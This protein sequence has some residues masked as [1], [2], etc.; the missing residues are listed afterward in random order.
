[1]NNNDK[2]SGNNFEVKFL[3]SIVGIVI[4]ISFMNNIF[5]GSQSHIKYD[6]KNPKF[7]HILSSYENSF[8]EDDLKNFANQNDMRINVTYMGD[9][10]IVDELNTN[11]EKY[12]A[13]WISNSMWLYMLNN[14]YLY[15]EQKSISISPVIFGIKKSKAESL[16]LVGKEVTN[17]DIV[18]LIQDKKISYVMSSVTRTNTGATAYFGF[19]QSLAG[20]PEVLTV[21]HL[22]NKELQ[23]NLKAI[24]SGVERVSG[25]ED[26]L[27]KMFLNDS[28]FEAVIADEGSL[29]EINKELE[30]NGK[31]TLYFIYPTDGVAMND[32]T[33]SFISSNH[34]KKDAF[35][36]LQDYLLSS[37]GRKVLDSKGK[38]TW[39]GGVKE[40]VDKSVFNPAWG[41]DT[42]K[43]LLVTKF[44][45]KNVMNEAL[46]V[47]VNLLRKPT[48]VAFCL[49][50]SGSMSGSRIKELKDAM[51]YILD[52]EQTAKERLQF[53]ENDKVS[54][55]MFE[56]K[57]GNVMTEAGNKTDGLLKS[58][59]AAYPGGATA[60][61]PCVE[62][63]S[64]YLE[65]DT[66]D[67]TKVVIAM[68]DGE[69][70]VGEFY[71]LENYFNSSKEKIPVYS[72]AFGDASEYQLDQMS[73]LT[74]GKTFNGKTGLLQA[75][76][77]VRGYN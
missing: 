50:Y 14:S 43:S 25:D 39:Y 75:F 60:L 26:Y 56:T 18:K 58:I 74:N 54:I 45:S 13:V 67:V 22:Q 46:N 57:V 64:R 32:S 20:N 69:A 21:E 52:P 63:A 23:E 33:F 24:F 71:V 47:Y 7:I 5:S 76:K 10:D 44:P 6:P 30:K 11:P 4:L 42:T 65:K 36:K 17:N 61:F 2:T 53:T 1:M 51:G 15:S 28:E 55:L 72:I 59:N 31:E 38:R 12:D 41:I 29:I 27:K 70:N 40:D 62:A 68:T 16:G 8:I 37:D 66:D 9:I 19:V 48:H 35:L 73:R 77:E 3:F 34:D 49:D